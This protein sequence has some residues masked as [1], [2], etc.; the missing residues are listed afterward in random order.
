[1][2]LLQAR[3]LGYVVDGQQVLNGVD[4]DLAPGERLA[5]MGP[6]GSGKTTLLPL[7]AGLTGA[8]ALSSTELASGF[9]T[10]MVISSLVC[11]AGG[12]LAALTIRNPAR[13]PR[14]VAAAEEQEPTWNCG[15]SG[16][17]LNPSLVAT[18]DRS[19]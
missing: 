14:A 10:A 5:V 13:T 9:R 15:V 17:P 2:N 16:P 12:L 3:D 19:S 8:A 4:L 7:L 11:A 18:V 6:S 1:M